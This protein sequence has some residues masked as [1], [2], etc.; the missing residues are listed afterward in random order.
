VRTNPNDP[1]PHLALARAL[2]Q[3]HEHTGQ[4]SLPDA[5]AAARRAARLW[6]ESSEPFLW[7]GLAHARS[8]RKEK[9]LDYL[10]RFVASS[11]SS[12]G[13]LLT[14]ARKYLAQHRG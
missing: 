8:G 7:E 6:P 2:V 3:Y 5:I 11:G 13:S 12:H 14:I 9:A 10:R 4:G 1:A